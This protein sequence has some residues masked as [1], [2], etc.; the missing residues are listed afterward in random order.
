MASLFYRELQEFGA[1][2][3]ACGDWSKHRL[4]APESSIKSAL[5]KEALQRESIEYLFEKLQKEDQRDLNSPSVRDLWNEK[6]YRVKD[7]RP[8]AIREDT[9]IAVCFYT[10]S[11]SDPKTIYR[12]LDIYKAGSF[13]FR[14]VSSPI[15]KPGTVLPLPTRSCTGNYSA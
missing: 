10:Q 14:T 13:Y 15:E 6:E 5:A 11:S 12:H 1:R 8:T 2:G 9:S 4:F 7:W 3:D